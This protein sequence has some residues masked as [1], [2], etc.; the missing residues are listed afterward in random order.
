MTKN[1]KKTFQEVVDHFMMSK[2]YTELSNSLQD[3]EFKKIQ[4]D[5]FN[6]LQ[7]IKAIA[8]ENNELKSRKIEFL[9]IEYLAKIEVI[10]VLIGFQFAFNLFIDLSM[11]G[12]EIND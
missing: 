11:V 2:T 10:G 8:T 12:G 7:K 1:T 5:F 9:V 4:I 6:T 3:E